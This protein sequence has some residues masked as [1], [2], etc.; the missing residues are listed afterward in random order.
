MSASRSS[1]RGANGSSAARFSFMSSLAFALERIARTRQYTLTLL[2]GLEDEQWLQM[3]AGCPTHIAWQVG[4]IAMAQYGLCLM[5]VRDSQ[6]GDRDLMSR[7]FR[8]QF[9]KGTTPDVD[10]AI[11]PAPGEIRRVF[12]AVHAQV[13]LE[14]PSFDESELEMPLAAPHQM[15]ATKIA[16]LHFSAD[17]E[18]L[19]AG[20][21]G[22]LRRLLGK[23]P[24]R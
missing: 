19:H 13:L 5:R 14:A 17:H 7:E 22:L 4:H 16:A 9:S 1:F 3:P 23:E 20:Q 2:E 11:N 10:P 8:K 18:M 12:D 15:F 6:P 21:I 24:V